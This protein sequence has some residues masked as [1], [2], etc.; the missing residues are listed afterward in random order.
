MVYVEMDPLGSETWR[1]EP[2]IELIKEGAVGVIP[3]DTVYAVTLR[4]ISSLQF[5]GL[6]RLPC[7]ELDAWKYRL[8]FRY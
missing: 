8:Q 5:C 7:F 3:T 6:L 4:F 2:V 1:L